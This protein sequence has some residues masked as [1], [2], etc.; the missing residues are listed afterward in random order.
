MKR[1]KLWIILFTLYC[2]CMLQL[3]FH[4][5]GYTPAL[6]YAQQLKYNLIPFETIVLFLR[7]LRHTSVGTRNHAVINLAGNVIMFIPL[8]FLL[9]ALWKPLRKARKIV[10]ATFLIMFPV[11]LLQMLTLVGSFDTDDLLLNILGSL[12]GYLL[13]RFV[14]PEK[15][16]GPH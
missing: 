12:L 6:P 16:A 14:Q 15:N 3:L 5:P 1:R 10:S 8:G 7:A 13:F 11:E 2:L 9:A 4:R